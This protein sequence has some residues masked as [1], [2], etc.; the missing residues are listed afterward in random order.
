MDKTATLKPI[1][2]T[3]MTDIEKARKLFSEA[4]LAFPPIPQNLAVKLRERE[5]W[6][7]STRPIHESPYDLAYYVREVQEKQTP[8]YALLSHSGHGENSYAIQ[9]Y[10]VHGSL[11]MF[12]HLCWGGTRMDNVKEAAKIRD[13]FSKT[14]KIVQL[15]QGVESFQTGEH[16]TVVASDFY[17]GCW[18]PPRAIPR[19]EEAVHKADMRHVSPLEM[20]TEVLDWL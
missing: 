20:L 4:G 10:L 5:R 3:P 19:E 14:D 13:C 6:V 2:E 12:L 11:R 9:Y 18:F 1:Q 8:D 16:L 17:G 7:F 15:L